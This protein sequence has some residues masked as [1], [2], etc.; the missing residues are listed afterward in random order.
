M[1]VQPKGTDPT[2]RREGSSHNDAEGQ[3]VCAKT[4][5]KRPQPQLLGEIET[6]IVGLQYYETKLEPGEYVSLEREL[7][8]P[9]DP[10][11]IRVENGRF[12]PG[13]IVNSCVRVMFQAAT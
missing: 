4:P 5:R 9:H 11:A 2:G 10:S 3:A 13:D 12:Q 7:D 6:E 1:L 8:N